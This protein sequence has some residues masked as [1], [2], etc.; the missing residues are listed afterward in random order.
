MKQ[1]KRAGLMFVAISLVFG[2]LYTTG[3]SEEKWNRDDPI[4]DEWNMIDLLVARPIGIA[5][6][7][8]GTGVF[9]LSLPFTIS[10]GSVNDAAQMFV[11]KPFNFSFT[12]SFP[13]DHLDENM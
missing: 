12:R 9:I 4:R 1:L 2:T 11:V 6:G 7:I 5:A 13:D 3:W 8:F 10:T